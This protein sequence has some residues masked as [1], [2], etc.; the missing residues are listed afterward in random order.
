MKKWVLNILLLTLPS[1]LIIIFLLEIT[2]RYI[3]PAANKPDLYFDQSEKMIHYDTTTNLTGIFTAGK[4]AQQKGKWSVNNFGWNSPYDY[5]TDKSAKL[6]IAVIGD[7]FIEALMVNNT[8]TYPSRL[9][10]DSSEVY[11]FGISGAPFSQYLHMSRYVAKTFDPDVFIFNIVYNDFNENLTEN[12]EN[13]YFK[14]LKISAENKITEVTP[15]PYTL[16]FSKKLMKRSAL[17]RYIYINLQMRYVLADMFEKKNEEVYNANVNVNEI[18]QKHEK[19]ELAVNYLCKKIREENPG[20][21]IILVMDGPRLDI[22]AGKLASSNV[23]FLNKMTAKYASL[24]KLDFIDLT[25]VFQ[26]DYIKNGKK[27]NS[28]WDSH[29]DDYGH[30][31]VSDTLNKF[32]NQRL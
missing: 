1:I 6:R 2:F 20:K 26:A 15:E 3:I 5:R 22:Y 23:L 14:T 27:F 24:Q 18:G 16:S 30:K 13:K 4:F 11:A 8:D 9:Q 29:W 12:Q 32:I 31:V 25:E 17:M 28:E 21:K 7:S 19:V 10:S